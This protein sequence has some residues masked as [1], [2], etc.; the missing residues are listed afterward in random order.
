MWI[1]Q[2]TWKVVLW[3][4]RHF[5][6]KNGEY[7]ACLKYSVLIVVEKIYKM[8]HLE[9]SVRPSYIWDAQLNHTKEPD[10]PLKMEPIQCSE[11]SAIN[12][13]TQGKHPKEIIF[14]LTHGESLKSRN[15]FWLFHGILMEVHV[16][17][18]CLTFH[19]DVKAHIFECVLWRENV[20]SSLLPCINLIFSNY[21]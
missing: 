7:A 12:T 18:L 6:E 17:Q 16:G 13:E 11:T 1:I 9:G 3:N 15:I 21:V 4:K 14:H 10:L 8:Q 2:E 5:E 20:T 19:L